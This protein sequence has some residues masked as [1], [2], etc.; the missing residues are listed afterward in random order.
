MLTDHNNL[1]KFMNIQILN[2]RQ[3]KRIIKLI[4]FDFEIKHRSKK[5]NFVNEFSK[6]SNYK[7]V[8]TKIQRLLFILQHKLIMFE[9]I[10]KKIVN[11]NVFFFYLFIKCMQSI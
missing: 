9:N 11:L 4:A 3:I 1:K 7:N 6:R 2:D 8:N 10:K 5:I